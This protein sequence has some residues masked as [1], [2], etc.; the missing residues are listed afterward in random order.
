MI[1][2]GV[3]ALLVNKRLI[4]AFGIS[5]LF[6]YCIE[7]SQLYQAD[8][9]NGIRRTYV[10][11]LVLGKGF[12]AVDLVR[13]SVGILLAFWIDRYFYKPSGGENNGRI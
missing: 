8:W 3:R 2:C 1:Y 7:F 13:Y 11:S 12:L 9:I 4:W 10:G 6:C 5:I